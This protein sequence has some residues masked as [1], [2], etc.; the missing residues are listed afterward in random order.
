MSWLIRKKALEEAGGLASFSEVLAEDFF[1]GKAIW[2][3]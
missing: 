3:Q 2:E 1:I